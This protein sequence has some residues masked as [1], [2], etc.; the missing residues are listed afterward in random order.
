M[1]DLAEALMVAIRVHAGQVD[2]Q[3]EPYLLH[4]LRVVD[5]VSPEAKVVAALHDVLEDGGDEALRLV[6][7]L[8]IGQSEGAA[9]RW[10]TRTEHESYADYVACIAEREGIGGELAREVK[11]ADLRDNLNRIPKKPR[12]DGVAALVW[13]QDCLP[14]KRRYEKA[15]ATLEASS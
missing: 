1:S 8:N 11:L 15:L 3:G 10:L 6:L 13:A 14:L 12:R 2:K 5:A 9:L 4:V 7:G